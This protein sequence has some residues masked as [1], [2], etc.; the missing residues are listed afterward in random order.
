MEKL[1]DVFGQMLNVDLIQMTLSNSRDADRAG[2][3]KIR[4]VLL[5]GEILFQ[6][7]TYRGTQVFHKNYTGGEL[8]PRLT[9]YMETLFKQAELKGKRE[10]ATVLVGKK[11]TVTVKRKKCPEGESKADT[12]AGS[13][14]HNRTKRYILQEGQPVDFLIGLGVQTPDGKI[15]K[16]RY[17]KFRQINRYL[18]F[19]EDVLD[20]LPSDRT[21]R[22]VDFGCGKSYLTFAM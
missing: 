5:K 1:R 21:L 14:S 15:A 2:K 16:A 18:E 13:L 12:N 6:E 10:E 22:I 11:G 17:D 19:I 3:I 8:L 7:T 20:R 9:E 4:P